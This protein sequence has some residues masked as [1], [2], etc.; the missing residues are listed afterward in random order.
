MTNESYKNIFFGIFLRVNLEGGPLYS[1]DLQSEEVIIHGVQLTVVFIGLHRS[2]FF[3]FHSF[4]LMD[5]FKSGEFRGYLTK[6]KRPGR[7]KVFYSCDAS[8]AALS[9]NG[10]QNGAAG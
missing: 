7:K 10:F 5:V 1:P 8:G 4:C 2:S 9:P 3:R 6:V